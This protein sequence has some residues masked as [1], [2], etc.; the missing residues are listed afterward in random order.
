MSI[1]ICNY[2][3]YLFHYGLNRTFHTFA[4]YLNWEVIYCIPWIGILKIRIFQNGPLVLIHQEVKT[5]LRN[6]VHNFF[7]QSLIGRTISCRVILVLKSINF[8]T[9][10]GI[11][12]GRIQRT[13]I[14]FESPRIPKF[15]QY[16]W[17]Y[18]FKPISPYLQA[19]FIWPSSNSKCLF[20]GLLGFE[21]NQ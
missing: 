19:W 12:V 6:H 11:L 1:F 18:T 20:W 16:W 7:H 10:D 3:L 21:N 17:N 13:A 9:C 14:S 4:G 5:F 2:R 15:S 8:V